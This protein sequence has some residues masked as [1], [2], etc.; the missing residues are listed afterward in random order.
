M[1][2][3]RTKT[4]LTACGIAVALCTHSLAQTTSVRCADRDFLGS[5]DSSFIARHVERDG[6]FA[7]VSSS[8]FR[9]QIVVFD[10]VDPLAPE[11]ISSFSVPGEAQRFAIRGT[12]LY[13]AAGPSGLRIYDIEDPRSVVEIGSFSDAG[14]GF[15]VDVVDDLAYIAAGNAGLQIVE[16][17]LPRPFRVGLAN[18]PGEARDVIVRD[19]F[20]FIADGAAGLSVVDV[21]EP[22]SPE[23]L[24]TVDTP[25]LARGIAMSG[26]FAF[27]ADGRE[28]FESGGGVQIFDVRDPSAPGLVA[29]YA[30]D[31]TAIDVRIEGSTLYVAAQ[32]GRVDVVDIADPAAPRTVGRYGTPS[33]IGA[34]DVD[35]GIVTIADSANDLRLLDARDPAGTP[36][37][38]TAGFGD[39]TL[40]DIAI[41]GDT[42]YTVFRTG[43]VQDTGIRVVDLSDPARPASIATLPLA[44]LFGGV[45]LDGAMLFATSGA[46]APSI[47]AISVAD[48]TDPRVVG[49]TPLADPVLEVAARD[50]LVFAPSTSEGLV[51]YDATD[52]GALVEIATLDV[53]PA[54]RVALGSG[55]AY[56][57]VGSSFDDARIVAVD[58]SDPASPAV[59]SE[60][61]VNGFVNDLEIIGPGVLATV[62][63]DFS[64]IDATDVESLAVAG[65]IDQP[66]GS[67]LDLSRQVGV[68]LASGNGASV[69]DIHDPFAPKPV[70]R[71][72]IQSTS[73]VGF[74]GDSGVITTQDGQLVTFNLADCCPADLDG[75][76][77]L[78]LFDLLAFQNAFDAGDPIADFDGDGLL[79]FFDFLAFQNAFDAG[80]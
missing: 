10:V 33:G 51:V 42:G 7:F 66:A 1:T 22:A 46:D 25:G 63:D 8:P 53:G 72:A 41:D 15:A 13:A 21:R 52:P 68:L 44:D 9:S 14:F 27:V 48:P 43:G 64:I 37:L 50:G 77:E 6:G 11:E 3:L 34:I 2:A 80:C 39:D 69:Y 38:G 55:V 61:T 70:G 36:V 32:P 19:G 54:N 28:P 47:V 45:A 29:S 78:T 17:D 31:A 67:F 56:V 16:L 79:T 35:D 75:D 59:L 71:V 5:A 24:A 12:T 74:L 30:P 26:D 58:V 40:F 73:S 76:G 20:A 62:G 49:T 18:T 60:V 23:L 4:R 65:T 57:K